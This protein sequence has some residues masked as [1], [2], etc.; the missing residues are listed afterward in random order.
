MSRFLYN[1]H[2]PFG[3]AQME[4]TVEASIFKLGHVN[5]KLLTL[6]VWFHSDTSGN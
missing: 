3:V 6:H 4:R 2:K 5:T 1:Q